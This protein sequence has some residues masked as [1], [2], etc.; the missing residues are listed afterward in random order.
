VLTGTALERVEI[1]AVDSGVLAIAVRISAPTP[2]G[3]RIGSQFAG[4]LVPTFFT[5]TS[6]SVADTV[7][8][9]TI[10]RV[11]TFSTFVE[12]SP[13]V[14]DPD[15]LLVGSAPSARA[16]LRS[17]CRRASGIPLRF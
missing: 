6:A 17:R 5:Y 13:P 2:T 8:N 7:S 1:P 3:I 16:M 12:Q 4:S 10:A 11:P 9:Q 14:A 15:L